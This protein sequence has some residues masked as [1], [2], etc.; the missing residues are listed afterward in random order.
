MGSRV[1]GATLGFVPIFVVGVPRSGTTWVQRILSSHPHAW[2][3]LETYMFSRRHG[4]GA[5]FGTLPADGRGEVPPGLG[6]MFTREELV[7]Q[8]RSVAVAWMRAAS[9]DDVEFVVEKSP[10]H[11]SEL[12]LIAEVLPEARFVHV[13][14]DGRDVAVSIVAARRSWSAYGGDGRGATVRELANVWAE[15]VEK[16]D[17]A[18]AVLGDRIAEVRFED[19]H[20]DRGNEIARLFAHC[21]MPGGRTTI[22]AAVAETDFDRLPEPRGEGRLYRGGR[23]GDWRRSFGMRDRYGFERV[24]GDAL[25]AAGYEAGPRWWLAGPLRSRL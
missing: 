16:A 19:L 1:A 4:L 3:L 23:V 25:R 15:G 17:V 2:P 13:L 6:R 21:G 18:R 7:A 20:A 8:V 12:D 22:D 5:L 11:L 14:R 9:P 10:W 24:A